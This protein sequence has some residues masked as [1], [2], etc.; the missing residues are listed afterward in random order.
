[1]LRTS[2]AGGYEQREEK[3]RLIG[4]T[5]WPLAMSCVRSPATPTPAHRVSAPPR[6]PAEEMLR[7]PRYVPYAAFD[8][9]RACNNFL[10]SVRCVESCGTLTRAGFVSR[11]TVHVVHSVSMHTPIAKGPSVCNQRLVLAEVSTRVV[12]QT[13]L[14]GVLDTVVS[15]ARE[16]TGAWHGGTIA[17]RSR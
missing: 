1:M 9:F 5:D 4:T 17:S 2:R 6:F 10:A 16:L 7:S 12:G 8:H 3:G 11:P 13:D 14:K 15:A